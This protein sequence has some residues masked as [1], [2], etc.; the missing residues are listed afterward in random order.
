M[1]ATALLNRERGLR[2]APVRK[3]DEAA[4][5]GSRDAAEAGGALYFAVALMAAHMRGFL[6]RFLSFIGCS[7]VV[8]AGGNWIFEKD[9]PGHIWLLMGGLLAAMMVLRPGKKL[10]TK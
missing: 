8:F 2:G 3:L 4:Q 7:M 9:L 6:P 10:E 5:T 1:I